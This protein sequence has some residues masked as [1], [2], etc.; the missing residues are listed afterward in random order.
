MEEFKRFRFAFQCCNKNRN[1]EQSEEFY[2]AVQ[3]FKK[4]HNVNY[5]HPKVRDFLKEFS[6]KSLYLGLR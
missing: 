6:T 5:N 3:C 2:W 1:I 4:L